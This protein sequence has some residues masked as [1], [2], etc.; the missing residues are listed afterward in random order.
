MEVRRRLVVV[1]GDAAARGACQTQVR[2]CAERGVS[3]WLLR[4][5]I[6]KRGRGSSVVKRVPTLLPIPIGALR[7]APE[8]VVGAGREAALEIALPNGIRVRASGQVA[9]EIARALARAL[10]C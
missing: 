3:V 6:V 10:R 2:F 8:E 7:S 5:W 4:K 9:T 1:H